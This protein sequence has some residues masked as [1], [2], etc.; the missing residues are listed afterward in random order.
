MT[1]LLNL[2]STQSITYFLSSGKRDK[3]YRL[4]HTFG[5]PPNLEPMTMHN[6]GL[7]HTTQD[8]DHPMNATTLTRQNNE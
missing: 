4:L 8:L 2:N 1:Q 7:G 3:A 6:T 5:N